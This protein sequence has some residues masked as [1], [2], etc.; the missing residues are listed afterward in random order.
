MVV[1][2]KGLH[3][4]EGVGKAHKLTLKTYNKTVA[5]CLDAFQALNVPQLF[6]FRTLPTH[7][8]KP[9]PPASWLC[10]TSQRYVL[11]ITYIR[12]GSPR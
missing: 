11:T 12:T 3:Q 10:R 5:A 1:F 9:D 7:F 4:A 2:N 6:W 8:N